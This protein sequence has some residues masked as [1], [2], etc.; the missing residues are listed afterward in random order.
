MARAEVAVVGAGPA[1]LAAAAVLADHSADVVLVDE[2]E[3]PGGQSFRQPPTTFTVTN[4][5]PSGSLIASA[6]VAGLRKLPRTVVWALFDSPS[7]AWTLGLAGDDGLDRLDVEHVVVAT[8]AVELPVAFPGWTVPGVMGAGGV[9]SFAKSEK[10]VPGRR[11]VL[12]GAHPLVL[13]V[14]D[15][16][17]ASGA[18]VAAVALAQPRP[19]MREALGAS[20]RLRGCLARVGG[21][22]GSLLRLRRAGVRVLF[23]HVIVA[24]VGTDAVEAVRLRPVDAEWQ[25]TGAEDVV[26]C[27]D[28]LGLGY[29]LV[30]ATELTRQAGC[31]HAWRS[32]AGGWIAEHDEWQRTDKVGISVAGETTGIAGAEQAVEEGRLAALG[33]LQALGRLEPAEAHRL[34]I[35]VRRRLRRLRRFSALVAES[36]E[37]R[38]DAL[39]LLAEGETVVCRCE[40]VTAAQLRAALAAHPH[41]GDVDAVKQLTRVGMGPCQGR[42]CHAT[43]A[44]LTA[45]AAARGF[46]EV[47]QYTSRP[48]AR[49]LR[50][51]D[52]A[53]ADIEVS[54]RALH[55]P[56][57]DSRKRAFPRSP[58]TDSNR[59]PPPC[60]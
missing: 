18:D 27:C 28:T 52:L 1:G 49:P 11:F 42:F 43:V 56:T 50:L 25:P 9:Q 37:P 45:D 17:A 54:D 16:L 4:R 46:D 26:V 53:D 59:R 29:G 41:L 44:A 38:R 57:P 15:Q 60:L 6:E 20:V 8:G 2:Q 12:A 21:A 36:F 31:A 34:A 33:V 5:V 7:Q 55:G 3:R 58:P 40:E 30:P 39:A 23:S 13:L 35:S 51:G 24:A 48:P 14:A 47:G 22:A 32:S 10:L 19:A